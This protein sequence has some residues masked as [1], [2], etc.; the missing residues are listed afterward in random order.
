[1]DI[2]T[3]S[4]KR[5]ERSGTYTLAAAITGPVPKAFQVP[6]SPED[7]QHASSSPEYNVV[8]VADVDMATP[9]FFTLREMGT[10]LRS[11]LSFDFD[12]VTFVLNI[13]DKLAGEDSLVA[14]RSRRP[15]HR[16]LTRIE[17]ATQQIRDRATIAQIGYMKEF[18]EERQKEEDALQKTVQELAERD[19]SQKELSREES[20]ELQSSIV[21]AQQRLTSVLDEK[22]RKFDRK[23]EE[24]QREVDEY[25][26]QTQGRYKAFAAILPPIP[27]LVIAL[28][29]YAYRRRRQGSS[30]GF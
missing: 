20:V 17:K 26:R 13:V 18:E 11:G 25:V 15:R 22:K 24:E 14:I 6:A 5:I 19:S 12:N 29:V 1:M 23:V 16:T 28:L 8:V 7:G 10:D 21:A 3:R 30:F 4:H 27:P 2:R 9:G